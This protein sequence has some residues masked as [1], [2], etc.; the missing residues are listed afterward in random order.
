MTRTQIDDS[1]SLR[2]ERPDDYEFMADLYASTRAEEMQLVD[3]SEQQKRA[4]L[5]SQFDAQTAHYRTHYNAAEFWIIERNGERAGRLYLHYRPDDLRIVDIALRPEFRGQGI[6]G[7]ILNQ[8]LGAAQHGGYGLSI[9]VE[10]NN[11][12]MRL[13]NRMGFRKIDEHGIYDLMEWKPSAAG[14]AAAT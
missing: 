13:Y 2:P 7:A 11:P 14:H 3:W 10:R 6:G 12:A 5:R 1:T 9:H 4:F 8:L